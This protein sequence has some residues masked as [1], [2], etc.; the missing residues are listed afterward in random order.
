MTLRSD[1][2]A[3]NFLLLK[4]NVRL[5]RIHCAVEKGMPISEYSSMDKYLP[6]WKHC[7]KVSLRSVDRLLR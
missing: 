6:A 3:M 1:V 2:S 5:R 4:L 7:S